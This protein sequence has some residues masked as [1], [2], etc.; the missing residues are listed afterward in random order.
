MHQKWP[1]SSIDRGRFD[2]SVATGRGKNKIPAALKYPSGESVA[3]RCPPEAVWW[4]VHPG[5]ALGIP[6][7]TLAAGQAGPRRA[8]GL[9]S[10]HTVVSWDRLRRQER[11][12]GARSP[13]WECPQGSAPALSPLSPARGNRGLPAAPAG[14]AAVCG[15]DRS[16]C[17]RVS[18]TLGCASVS[19][20]ASDAQGNLPP[21]RGRCGEVAG[22]G[23]RWR[24]FSGSGTS[25]AFWGRACV[26]NLAL[27]PPP[28]AGVAQR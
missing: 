6:G 14:V 2:L 22:A 21:S 9:R 27:T 13:F 5:D 11:G 8:Q 26:C 15:R 19:L 1:G 18:P 7:E 28:H 10:E 16:P 25:P 23:G 3:P 17:C 24:C 20:S 4:Q 12:R